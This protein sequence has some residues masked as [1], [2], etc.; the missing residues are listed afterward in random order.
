MSEPASKSRA[1]GLALSIFA[2]LVIVYWLRIILLPFVFAGALAYLARPLVAGLRRLNFPRWAA[3]LVPLLL[4]LLLLSGL[5]YA[6]K[7]LLAP[8][9]AAMINNLPAV[10]TEFL[11]NLLVQFHLKDVFIFGQPVDPA[12]ASATLI[13]DLKQT[14]AANVFPT[15]GGGF[16][17]I[18]GAVL[19]MVLFAFILFTGPRLRQGILWLIPPE[20]RPR[21][22][23]LARQIDP[24]LASYLR[25][26]FIIVVFTSCV[27]YLVTG[28]VFHVHNAFFLALAVGLL[29]LLPV[30]GPILSFI[31]FA[32]VAVQQTSIDTIIAFGIFAIVLRLV[33]DQLIGPLVLG[34]AA[35]I[36]AVA[37]IFAFLAGGVL[38]GM[39]GVILA[40]PVAATV[41]V[42]LADLYENPSIPNQHR[43]LQ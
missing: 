12:S 37:V 36:P 40:V 30:I 6:I 5:G 4:F 26:V 2:A 15:I 25:G 35:Q 9:I 33:I 43:K 19:T 1:W 21:A 13:A 38:Y 20:F 24:L 7:V 23:R 16:G 32:L 18:M 31:A 39:L 17:A 27:T 8:Q 3:S 10:L 41:K 14:A 29:E 28:I 11:D 34:R 22:I 42:L